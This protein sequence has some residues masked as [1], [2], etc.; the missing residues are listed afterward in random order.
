M[1]FKNNICCIS[2]LSDTTPPKESNSTVPSLPT[3]SIAQSGRLK[4]V[5]ILNYAKQP[6]GSDLDVGIQN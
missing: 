1:S 2:V 3:R 6:D 4:E 5:W